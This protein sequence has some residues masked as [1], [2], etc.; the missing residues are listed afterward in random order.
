MLKNKNNLPFWIFAFT[1]FVGLLLPYL[2]QNGMFMDGVTYASISKNMANGSGSFWEPHYTQTLYST[3]N[4]H[5]P[6]AFGIQS[7]FFN[8]FGDSIYTERIFSFVMA[9][10]SMLGIVL[11]WKTLFKNSE[12][13]KLSWI[14]VLL[15]IA[16][17]VVH[18]SFRNNML[19]NTLTMFTLFSVYF[20]LR[21]IILDKIS[22]LLPASLLILLSFLTKGP[23]GLFPLI[24]VIVY[25]IINRSIS[26]N[27]QIVYT[28]ILVVTPIIMLL[29]LFYIEPK[30]LE[31]ITKYF[32]T[33]LLPAIGG[34]REITGGRFNVLIKLIGEI[35][36]PLVVIL[37]IV[38]HKRIKK[39]TSVDL[40]NKQA[41]FFIVIALC[42]TLPLIITLKQMRFYIVPSIPFF[43]LGF[44]V[45][46]AQYLHKPIDT[47]TSKIIKRLK[48][49][50]YILL[51]AVVIFSVTFI[52]KTSRNKD[53][54]QDVYKI[55][56]IIPNG[57]IVSVPENL[58]YEWGLVAC[59]SRI[60]DISLDMDNKNIYY[61]SEKGFNAD[62]IKDE[63]IELTD[64]DLL[65]YR[66]Y[67]RK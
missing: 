11:I 57:E 3:F 42:A 58:Y 53:K 29:L 34:S 51:V 49:I 60:G 21:A 67:K 65:N 23:V 47:I 55:A 52:G 63:Y 62:N 1:L 14:P 15:W 6:L 30:S 31:N 61:L 41:L 43:V 8:L 48:L 66:V 54:L 33:Q 36:F 18:W 45:I 5:P 25:W 44:S 39:I 40:N 10:L 28:I 2:L 24:T 50:S 20:I 16:T 56:D 19:E 46:I 37:F 9:L 64:I 12:I 4:E 7:I 32:N 35:S 27:K 13:E 26:F 59:L 22:Y 38:L 17:P